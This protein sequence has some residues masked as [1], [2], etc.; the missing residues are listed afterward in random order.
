MKVLVID[1]YD[2]FTFNLAQ[3]VGK[4]INNVVVV[5]NDRISL[6]EIESLEVDKIVI[7]PGPG[8]PQDSRI[9][10]DVIKELGS[11]IPV[12][13]VCLGHQGIGY[14]HGARIIHAPSL[15]HGKSS[16]IDH[17]EKTIFKQIPQR[18]SAARYHSLVIDES[19]IPDELEISAR[20]VDGVVMGVRHRSKPIEGIQFHPES[21]L[22]INGEQLIKNWIEL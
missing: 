19:T 9:S 3:L 11:K 13:G 2:S 1:N 17:D 10:L 4:I 15:M 20:S 21:V 5:R 12:L 14:I 8:K 16:Q 7:S 6:D 22:T 18:F